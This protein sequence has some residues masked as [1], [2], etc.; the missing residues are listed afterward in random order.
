M[1][2]TKKFA[3]ATDSEHFP[4]IKAHIYRLDVLFLPSFWSRIQQDFMIAQVFFHSSMLFHAECIMNIW[5]EP[6]WSWNWKQMS[7]QILTGYIL[8]RLPKYKYKQHNSIHSI[9][10][11]SYSFQIIYNA[12]KCIYGFRNVRWLKHYQSEKFV[13]EIA[14]LT[15]RNALKI[16]SWPKKRTNCLM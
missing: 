2:I 9:N 1:R 4:L 16:L 15:V 14:T 6:Y 10:R 11:K 12:Y 5:I 7:K 13:G 8:V 3:V